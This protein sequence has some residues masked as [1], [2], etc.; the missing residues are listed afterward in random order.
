[1]ESEFDEELEIISDK[2]PVHGILSI[3][4]IANSGESYLEIYN[5]TIVVTQL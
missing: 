5:K 2:T 1:M 3:G 4:E